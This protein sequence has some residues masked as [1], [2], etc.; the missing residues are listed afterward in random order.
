M[1]TTQ[2]VVRNQT[3]SSCLVPTQSTFLLF[4]SFRQSKVDSSLFIFH[5]GAYT[6]FFLL[7]VEDIVVTGNNDGILQ[8]LINALGRG[9][10]IKDLGPLHYFLGLQVTTKS[11]G[12]RISQLKYDYDILVKH[13]LLLCKFASTPMSAKALLIATNG[14]YLQILPFFVKW[15]AL[16]SISPSLAQ[17]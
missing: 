3:S 14:D 16:S 4:V 17:T 9:F 7:Y 10:D 11:T 5:Q 1:Q 12:I 6:I 15:L 8:S 2:D 13:D